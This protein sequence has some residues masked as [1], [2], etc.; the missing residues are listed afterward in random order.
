M[1]A[2]DTLQKMVGHTYI[3]KARHHK[4]LSFKQNGDTVTVVTDKEW[5]EFESK[6]I[7]TEL[8][9]F[10][11]ADSGNGTSLMVMKTDKGNVLPDL[12]KIV[13]DNINQVRK[14][15]S[16]IPQANSV[17]KS[18]NSLINMAKLELQIK[19]TQEDG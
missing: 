19:K 13:M 2:T 14:D 4:I 16:Y 6:T 18:I 1:L 9:K 12:A 3:Y 10:L 8:K 17:T 11:P 7:N 15:K 5:L